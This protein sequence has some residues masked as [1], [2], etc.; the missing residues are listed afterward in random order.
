MWWWA[1]NSGATTITTFDGGATGDVIYIKF[2][3]ANT[4]IQDNTG[5]QL[6]GGANKNFNSDDVLV[7]LHDGT[8]WLEVSR[9][10]N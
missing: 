8:N 6:A 2:N 4:T 3:N 1:A 7:L 9:S 10:E 5:I